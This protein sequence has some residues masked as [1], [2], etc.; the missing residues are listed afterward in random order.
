[1]RKKVLAKESGLQ[2]MWHSDVYCRRNALIFKHHEVHAH[3]LLYLLT[4]APEGRWVKIG[5][6]I[7]KNPL[8]NLHVHF[9]VQKSYET[10]KVYV[11]TCTTTYYETGRWFT[12]SDLVGTWVFEG[13][14]TADVWSW[15]VTLQ[16]VPLLSINMSAYLIQNNLTFLYTVSVSH[17]L[18]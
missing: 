6:H 9:R 17:E 7:H 8:W 15:L 14:W 3:F 2:G 1:V 4:C 18:R 10:W 16:L 13:D 5:R 11:F 12:V